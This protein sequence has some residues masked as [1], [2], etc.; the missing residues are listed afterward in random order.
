MSWYRAARAKSAPFPA[1][2]NT[3]VSIIGSAYSPP[4]AGQPV[5]NFGDAGQKAELVLSGGGIKPEIVLPFTFD[6]KG[7]ALF[8]NPGQLHP[9][10]TLSLT[11]GQISGSVHVP[12]DKAPISFS[13]VAFPKQENGAGYFI[14][15]S[16]GGLV[17][18]KAAQ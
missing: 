12:G 2:F 3:N 6:T 1:A 14:R 8:S 4:Q 7:H 17:E 15:L 9:S 10:L 16:S 11:D 13:G 5:F 18:L